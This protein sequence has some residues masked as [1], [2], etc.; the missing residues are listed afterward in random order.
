MGYILLSVG[1]ALGA[2]QERP[3]VD[4]FRAVVTAAAAEAGFS[5]DWADGRPVIVDLV[6]FRAASPALA[7]LTERAAARALQISIGFP[8]HR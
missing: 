4:L 1:V 8:V 3:D 7:A 5:E 6:T 2:L